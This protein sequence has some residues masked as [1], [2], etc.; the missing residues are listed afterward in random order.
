[1][2]DL[3]REARNAGVVADPLFAGL[4]RPAMRFGVSYLALLVNL[5]VT[6]ECFL[7]SRN[8]LVLLLAV[9]LHGVFALLCARD[10]R[11]LDLGQLWLR[12]GLLSCLANR[13][14]WRGSS[15]SPLTLDLPAGSGHRRGIPSAK[16]AHRSRD[17]E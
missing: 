5:V 7:L 4:T 8:V 10:A 3:Q 9:P 2:D 17:S 16:W 6:M 12:T 1:M 15:Y 14:L 13:R 11:I